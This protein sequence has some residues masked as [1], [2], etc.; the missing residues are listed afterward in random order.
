M[1]YDFYFHTIWLSCSPVF[2][3][4]E[5]FENLWL[6]FRDVLQAILVAVLLCSSQPLSLCCGDTK[7]VISERS[8]TYSNTFLQSLLDARWCSK[9]FQPLLKILRFARICLAQQSY[10]SDVAAW[11]PLVGLCRSAGEESKSSKL[12]GVVCGLI[13][14]TT[15]SGSK[16]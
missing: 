15:H 11:H 2:A 12:R 9:L 1:G 5:M 14:K 16:E 4:V 13:E 6:C 10:I 8:A 7:T 3:R